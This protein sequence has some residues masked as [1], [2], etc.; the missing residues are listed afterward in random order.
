MAEYF[1]ESLRHFW[2]LRYQP[3]FAIGIAG[4]ATVSAVEGHVERAARL[5]GAAE[6]LQESLKEYRCLAHRIEIARNIAVAR[7]CVDAETWTVRW[8]EG[9]AL[10]LEQAVAE[11]LEQVLPHAEQPGAIVNGL[12]TCAAQHAAAQTAVSLTHREVDVLQ[13]VAQGL[14]TSEVAAELGLSPLT[15]TVHLRA[16]YRKLG[17][18]SR[19]AATRVAI[20][21]HL[22]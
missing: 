14:R 18:R 9:R 17:V 7:Q 16:I 6:A 22:V 15:V 20:E 19:T 3:G 11:A 8:V 12:H 1:R 4:I 21:Q 13:L 10:A 5:F 2:Q